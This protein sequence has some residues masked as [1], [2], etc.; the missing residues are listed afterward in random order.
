LADGA[1]FF[2]TPAYHPA[3]K[4]TIVVVGFHDFHARL[5]QLLTNPKADS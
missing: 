5:E 4:I 1:G 2:R 3:A